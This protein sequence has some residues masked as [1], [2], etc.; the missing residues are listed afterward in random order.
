[1][2]HPIKNIYIGIPS[3]YSITD[4]GLCGYMLP[5]APCSALLSSSR[6]ESTVLHPPNID[7]MICV[8]Y[9]KVVKCEG[10][11]VI[12]IEALRSLSNNRLHDC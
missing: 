4:M 1:M 5:Y 10:I 11:S 8:V 12:T 3:K 6:T 2:S 7:S 9:V